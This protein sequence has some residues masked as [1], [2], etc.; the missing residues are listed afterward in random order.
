[1]NKQLS[2]FSGKLPVQGADMATIDIFF[3]S[4]RPI[5]KVWPLTSSMGPIRGL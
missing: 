2:Y 3:I 1:M 4:K 5:I